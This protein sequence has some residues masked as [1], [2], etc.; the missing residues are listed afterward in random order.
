LPVIRRKLD[1]NEVYSENLRYDEDTDTVQS[2]VNGEWVDN[3]AADPRTQTLF[4][5]IST[6]DPACD[7][8]QRVSDAFEGQI[9][10]IITLI[11]ESNTFFTI[12]G[13]ILALFEFGPFG[14]FI[15]LAIA[16]AH[17][18]LDA[19]TVALTAAFTPA[20]WQKFKCI[21]FC[22]FNAQGRLK[23]DGFSDLLSKVDSLI[24]GL[25]GTILHAM[26]SLAG[27]G[28]VNNLAA[29]GTA[30][31]D[32]SDCD[33]CVP[34]CDSLNDW[35]AVAQAGAIIARSDTYIDVAAD[36]SSGQWQAAIK[37]PDANSTAAICCCLTSLEVIDGSSGGAIYC[38]NLCGEVLND[39]A[40]AHCGIIPNA[41]TE[42]VMIAVASVTGGFTIRFHFNHPC[43]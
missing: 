4:P 22:E 7:A 11:T 15:A 32:C 38:Y 33:A 13:A 9:E 39:F 5:P 26:C 1:P 29:L 35:E 18:M 41:A 34:P 36:H 10:Q 20:V 17:V 8:A 27:E 43:G 2:L 24:G 40:W 42:I 6:S 12:A 14:L 16:L 25:A 37:S 31:G 3:S 28:G 30:T 21:L 23:P 19:G